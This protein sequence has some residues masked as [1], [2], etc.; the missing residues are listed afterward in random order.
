[1]V[2]IESSQVSIIA[3]IL[4]TELSQQ[5]TSD[6]ELTLYRQPVCI[7]GFKSTTRYSIV[8]STKVCSNFLQEQNRTLLLSESLQ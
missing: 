4:D 8:E 2:N 7:V 6:T 3:V 1:M 5:S